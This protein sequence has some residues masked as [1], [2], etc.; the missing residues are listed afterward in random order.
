MLDA[1]PANVTFDIEAPRAADAALSPTEKA[2]GAMAAT[3]RFFD[4][5]VRGESAH[6]RN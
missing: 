3:R 2:K 5:Y 4:T 6:A 1:L